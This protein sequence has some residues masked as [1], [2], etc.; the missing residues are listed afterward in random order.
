MKVFTH[1]TWKPGRNKKWVQPTY[2]VIGLNFLV[3]IRHRISCIYI[4][5]IWSSE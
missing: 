3:L 5:L 4:A 1:D 2:K